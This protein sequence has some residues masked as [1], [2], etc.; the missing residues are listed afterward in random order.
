MGLSRT[1]IT[2]LLTVL[3]I[4]TVGFAAAWVHERNQQNSVTLSV[5][6]QKLQIKTQ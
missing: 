2:L 1:H 5:G 3:V 4:A 6:D